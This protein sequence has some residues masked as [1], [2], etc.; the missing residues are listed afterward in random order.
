MAVINNA[1]DALSYSVT[2]A[3][4]FETSRSCFSVRDFESRKVMFRVDDYTFC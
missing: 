1:T 3:C 4:A 2:Y